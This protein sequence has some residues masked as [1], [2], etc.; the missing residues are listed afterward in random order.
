MEMCRTTR[1]TVAAATAKRAQH[2]VH[3]SRRL[4]QPCRAALTTVAT[5]LGLDWRKYPDAPLAQVVT[6]TLRRRARLEMNDPQTTEL[7]VDRT[8][9]TA[10]GGSW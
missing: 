5:N 8:S 3:L 4:G 10:R 2:V 6:V 9:R 1:A 7:C